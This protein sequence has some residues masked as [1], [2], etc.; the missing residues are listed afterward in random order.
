M[1]LAGEKSLARKSCG[2]TPKEGEVVIIVKTG[3]HW[4]STNA[5]NL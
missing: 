4:Y 5:L 3:T 1:E 2:R